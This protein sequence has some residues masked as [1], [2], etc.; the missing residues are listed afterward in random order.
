M[1]IYKVYLEFED[2]ARNLVQDFV[3]ISDQSRDVY[4]QLKMKHTGCLYLNRNEQVD[5]INKAFNN[6]K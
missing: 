4:Y 3:Y 2:N 1:H 6:K 5:L